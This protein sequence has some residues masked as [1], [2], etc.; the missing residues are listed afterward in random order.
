MVLDDKLSIAP[1]SK[2]IK[3]ALIVCKGYGRNDDFSSTTLLKMKSYC[4]SSRGVPSV[5]RN[6]HLWV[7]TYTLP[8]ES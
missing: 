1:C 6:L 4:N 8:E 7:V 2:F 5:G 3:L